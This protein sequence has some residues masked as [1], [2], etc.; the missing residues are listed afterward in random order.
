MQR[1]SG[2]DK[3]REGTNGTSERGPHQQD[4]LV[5]MGYTVAARTM[6]CIHSTAK[7]LSK[8][9]E[10]NTQIRWALEIIGMVCKEDD[11]T[12]RLRKA[13]DD[14]DFKALRR[15]AIYILAD[16][17]KDPETLSCRVG[18][19]CRR[20]AALEL[21]LAK[22]GRASSALGF[23]EWI[24]KALKGGGMAAHRWCNAPNS[25]RP[26]MA[27]SSDGSFE[28]QKITDEVA[29]GW[30]TKW[31]SGSTTRWQAAAEAVNIYRLQTLQNQ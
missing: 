31:W 14:E 30:A 22:H 12:E 28:P 18:A 29:R 24:N 19:V 15:D 10:V 7:R 25:L 23:K 1:E 17:D 27:V 4:L 8:A 6:A 26:P 2:S 11:N 5:P 9:T 20:S 16:L 3:V 13:L 21:Q